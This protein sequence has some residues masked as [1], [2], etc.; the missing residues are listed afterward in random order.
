MAELSVALPG[1]RAPGR[2]ARLRDDLGPDL[3][4]LI[5]LMSFTVP[6]GTLTVYSTSSLTSVSL[7]STA[8][9]TP[10]ILLVDATERVERE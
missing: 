10:P 4:E 6:A 7:V 2:H 9:W 1:A 8:A 3:P 5:V